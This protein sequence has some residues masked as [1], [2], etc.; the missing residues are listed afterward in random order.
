MIRTLTQL[1]LLI[2]TLAVTAGSGYLMHMFF[3]AVGLAAFAVVIL[4]IIAVVVAAG[5]GLARSSSEGHSHP[6]KGARRYR[7]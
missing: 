4:A 5:G 6:S 1:A 2:V 3:G 7:D